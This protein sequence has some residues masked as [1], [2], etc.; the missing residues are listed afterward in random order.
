LPIE[1]PSILSDFADAISK[2]IQ[3]SPAENN[4]SLSVSAVQ[5]QNLTLTAHPEMVNISNSTQFTEQTKQSSQTPSSVSTQAQAEVQ[6]A[7]QQEMMA[8]KIT[9]TLMQK[10]K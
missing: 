3:P 6:Q 1:I 10:K 9:E 2:S 8:K 5:P 7:I 4:T